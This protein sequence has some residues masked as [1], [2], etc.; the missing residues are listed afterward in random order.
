[1]I[2]DQI[3][4]DQDQEIV[5]KSIVENKVRKIKKE[6]IHQG[7]EKKTEK[8]LI[9]LLIV[10]KIIEEKAVVILLLHDLYK[11]LYN[12]IEKSRSRN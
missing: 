11:K 10:N 2:T 1:M 5:L 6:N 9:N 3:V 7:K 12:L 8:D 4:Q